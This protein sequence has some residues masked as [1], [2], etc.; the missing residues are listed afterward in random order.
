MQLGQWLAI[1]LTREAEMAKPNEKQRK[2]GSL[3][4]ELGSC[5]SQALSLL[6]PLNT[7]ATLALEQPIT[8]RPFKTMDFMLCLNGHDAKFNQ[9]PVVMFTESKTV[10]MTV[11]MAA[12][13]RFQKWPDNEH[14]ASIRL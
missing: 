9:S 1:G 8:N 13:Q 4:P 10:I 3:E 6:L 2:Q 11:W 5:F 7:T 12:W 14:T